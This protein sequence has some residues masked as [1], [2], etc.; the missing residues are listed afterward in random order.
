MNVI[1]PQAA[2]LNETIKKYSPTVSNL[3]SK[4]GN[5]IFFPRKGILAQGADAKGKEIDATLGTAWNDD[6]HPMVLP[7]VAKYID[8]K[9]EEIFPYAP[10][11]GI[12]ELRIKWREMLTKKNPSLDGK[13]ISQPVVTNALTHALSMLGY[14]FLNEGDE[15]ILANL[16]W[17]NYKLVFI[18][19]Y[20]AKLK[21][22]NLF[23]DGKFD[24]DSFKETLN[25]GSSKKKI[26]ILNFPNNPSGYMPTKE[27]TAEI[28][29]A[30][31]ET[32]DKGN[33]M[34][35]ILDDAYFGL[36]YEEGITEE[37]LF[38][39]LADFHENILAVKADGVTKEEYAWG[40]RVGFITYGI[41]NG[42]SDL[43]SALQAKTGGAVRGSISNAPHLSQSLVL[44]AFNSESYD[45]EKRINF[46]KLN[47]RYLTVKKILEDH[48]EYKEFFEALPFNSGY[49]MC[50]KVKNADSENV[51]LTLLEKYS[52][53]V[54]SL[55][56]HNLLR[57]A[58]SSTPTA[59]LEKLFSNIYMACK[60]EIKKE[61]D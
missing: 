1:D 13:A 44:K 25:S 3:L 22:F 39:D 15:I 21:P 57:I 14:L 49:F 54:I 34:L 10:S 58:Y 30:L 7:S 12:R 2:E 61:K 51:R 48:P 8:I 16:F 59:N 5:A 32:A 31:K 55:N 41:K 50:V 42:S 20:G 17:G 23:K 47:K 56:N 19:N 28:K 6:E 36:G 60:D 26:V 53:G 27:A 37:S 33:E 46:Q 35:V 38:A 18:N 9:P 43:Y 24:I 40:L 29:E 4:K 11:F 52:T 45:E